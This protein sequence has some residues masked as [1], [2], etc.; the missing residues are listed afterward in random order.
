MYSTHVVW[1]THAVSWQLMCVWSKHLNTQTSLQGHLCQLIRCERVRVCVCV[2][3]FQWQASL[4]FSSAIYHPPG[5]QKSLSGQWL[6]D[7][8]YT[9][10]C[11]LI[12][13]EY[14]IVYACC[15]LCVQLTWHC[16][17]FDTEFQVDDDSDFSTFFHSSSLWF[18]HPCL[19]LSLVLL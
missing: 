12:S 8:A 6:C 3:V 16:G 4:L 15:S 10:L 19:S 1:C 18:I 14:H 13:V 2:C 17:S 7:I 11:L 9:H 5:R